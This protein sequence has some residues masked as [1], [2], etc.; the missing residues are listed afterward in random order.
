MSGSSTPSRSDTLPRRDCP[1]FYH[2][3]SEWKYMPKGGEEEKEYYLNIYNHLSPP[4]RAILTQH[5]ADLK[6]YTEERNLLVSRIEA[7]QTYRLVSSSIGMIFHILLMI[8]SNPLSF[9]TRP[10][11]TITFPSLA[12]RISESWGLLTLSKPL[13]N[14]TF[15]GRWKVLELPWSTLSWW[16]VY[17]QLVRHHATPALRSDINE[18]LLTVHDNPGIVQAS[19]SR[20]LEFNVNIARAILL[21][22]SVVYERDIDL[23]Q[24]AAESSI[25]VPDESVLFLIK[26]EER[27]FQL[28]DEW[29]LN[30]VSVA[31]CECKLESAGDFLATG[32]AH[33]GFYTSLFPSK[34]RCHQVLPYFC[35]IQV[36]KM[37]A[38]TAIRETGKKS[39]LFIGGHSLGAGIASLLYARL[40]ESPEDLGDQIVLRD[41]YT[42]GTPQSCDAKLASR[43]DFNLNKPIN[44]GRQMWRV[45][46]RSRSPIIGDLITR[47]PPGIATSREI[48]SSLRDGSYLSYA[49]IGIRVDLKPFHAPPFYTIK[50]IPAGYSV[51]VCKSQQDTQD[52]FGCKQEMSLSGVPQDIVQFSM[53]LVGFF[54]PFLYD[55]FPAGYMH[56]LNKMQANPAMNTVLMNVASPGVDSQVVVELFESGATVF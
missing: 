19:S 13:S 55:H 37:I 39:N 31:N 46:N 53:E 51:S 28:T 45:C 43:V 27:M 8:C 18:N 16:F 4:Q 12:L 24:K 17:D 54:L 41:A 23:V 15:F 52:E 47:V 25:C 20:R 48:R 14:S 2:D 34:S 11:N 30:F 49:S 21:M 5:A 6:K 56:A 3:S 50:D 26:S 36:V 9:F 40:L 38:N 35:I 44:Q 42:F 10:F 29:G 1:Y 32:M 22:C 33:E 7:T